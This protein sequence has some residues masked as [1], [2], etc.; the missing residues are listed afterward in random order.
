MTINDSKEDLTPK[1]TF[2]YH[3]LASDKNTIIMMCGRDEKV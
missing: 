3:K 1:K 2:I